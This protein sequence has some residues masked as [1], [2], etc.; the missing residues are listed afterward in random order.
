ML[1]SSYLDYIILYVKNDYFNVFYFANIGDYLI[2]LAI[3]LAIGSVFVYLCWFKSKNRRYIDR[4]DVISSRILEDYP[5]IAFSCMIDEFWTMKYLSS[6]AYKLLGYANDEVINNNSISYNEIIHP[7]YRDFVK[8]RYLEVVQNNTIFNEEYLIV[9]K[10]KQEKWVR[11]NGSIV[12]DEYN[13]PLRIEGYINDITEEKEILYQK[14]MYDTRYRSFIDNLDFPVLIYHD[15][16]IINVN[17]SAINF[18]KGRDRFDIEGIHV[19]EILD[20]NYINYYRKR[21]KQIMDTKSA[22]LPTNYKFKLLDGSTKLASLQTI[23][24]FIKNELY[25]HIILYELD[26]SVYSVQQLRRMQRRNRD[27]ILY[28][29]EGIGVFQEIPGERDGKLVFANRNFSKF[30]NRGSKNLIY[31]RFT[32]IFNTLSPQEVDKA[33]SVFRNDPYELEIEDIDNSRYYKYLFYSNVDNELVVQITDITDVKLANIKYIDEKTNLDN[34]LEETGL[35]VWNWDFTNGR[36]DFD[37]QWIIDMGYNLE[38]F[39]DFSFQDFSKL[40]HPDDN[41]NSWE[42]LQHYLDSDDDFFSLELRVKKSDGTYVWGL[43]RG[44]A[45]KFD[46]RL[47]PLLFRGTYQDITANKEKDEEIKFLSMHD[48]LTGLANRRAYDLALQE[49]ENP[50]NYPIAV[51][52]ADVNGLKVTN[53]AFGHEKG[54]ELLETVARVLKSETN[55]NDIL[56]RIGGDEFVLVSPNTN[57]KSA[58]Q[59]INKF[60]SI[61]KYKEISELPISVSFGFAIKHNQDTSFKNIQNLAESNMYQSKLALKNSRLYV[62]NL[63]RS[64]LFKI[65]PE[66]KQIV[67]MVN[68]YALKLIKF[69]DVTPEQIHIIDIATRYYNIGVISIDNKVFSNE[70]DFNQAEETEYQKHVE[71][72]YRI[73]LSTYKYDEVALA[74]LHH[75]ERF[76]GSGYPSSLKGEDIP[77]ASR[78]IACL[79]TYSRHKIINNSRKKAINYL[80]S[81]KGKGFD[82]DLVDLL[83]SKVL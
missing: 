62:V 40:I 83:V 70:R 73:M 44:K 45:I 53:D 46:D 16:H 13:Q 76:D 4:P 59:L 33:L 79:A 51:I 68:E 27:L 21:V 26:N 56:A 25:L 47:Q 60:H 20:D 67:E 74:I 75:H 64:K 69:L 14:S 9:T 32:S 30:V 54:D 43:M 28:M 1:L 50:K 80:K 2:G 58:T 5:G 15:H 57:Q 63:I 71:S 35:I 42:Q 8:E 66:E 49:I 17:P 19:E 36:L 48:H 12:Y 37:K 52:L 3:G 24:F 77:I 61:F 7:K 39:E 81:E 23:P 29:N 55:D 41:N 10:D 34:I 22:N 11:E 78:I 65:H 72:G 38:E 6:N 31:Q 82:P 18:F